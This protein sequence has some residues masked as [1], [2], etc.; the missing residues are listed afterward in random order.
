MIYIGKGRWVNDVIEWVIRK[1]LGKYEGSCKGSDVNAD[2]FVALGSW[3][4]L[5]LAF[6]KTYC[7]VLSTVDTW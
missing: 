7:N 4:F 2:K 3:I 5:F 6:D 1:R